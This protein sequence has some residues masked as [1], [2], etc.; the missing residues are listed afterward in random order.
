M[1]SHLDGALRLYTRA[2]LQD[3]HSTHV[4]HAGKAGVREKVFRTDVPIPRETLSTIVQAFFVWNRDVASYFT[5][6]V[7][8]S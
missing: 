5:T 2:E 1:I 4:R 8:A 6:T 3:R 7:T